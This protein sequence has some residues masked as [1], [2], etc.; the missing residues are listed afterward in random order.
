MSAEAGGSQA[1]V[2][3]IVVGTVL[4]VMMVVTGHY[5]AAVAALFAVGGM[6]ISL[7]AGGLYAYWARSPSS[8]AASGGGAV[9]GGACA[10]LGIAVSVLL[11]DVPATL[12]TFGTASSAITGAVGG[13]IGRRVGTRRPALAH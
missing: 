9:A 10:L 12:L 8:R 13:L 2:R 1:L 4:Q 5:V 6:G 3:A 7:L 11:G